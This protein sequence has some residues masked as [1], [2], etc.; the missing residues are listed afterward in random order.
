MSWRRSILLAAAVAIAVASKV[1][2]VRL[3]LYAAALAYLGGCVIGGIFAFIRMCVARR[4]EPNA[5]RPDLF[6][7]AVLA[8]LAGLLWPFA[9][10]R[11]EA[12]GD[13]A[14]RQ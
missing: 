12:D 5:E 9:F 10:V 2:V 3:A 11:D 1:R 13:R 4:S 7:V 14:R 6:T 8:V